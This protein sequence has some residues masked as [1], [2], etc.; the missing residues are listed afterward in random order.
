MRQT[1]ESKERRKASIC[2]PQVL[3][4]SVR[5]SC[6]LQCIWRHENAARNPQWTNNIGKY[7]KLLSH[8]ELLFWQE[9][10]QLAI[11]LSFQY[12]HS[13]IRYHLN[14]S[15]SYPDICLRST[16]QDVERK[17][18]LCRFSVALKLSAGQNQLVV[19]LWEEQQKWLFLH[20]VCHEAGPCTPFNRATG[21]A[22]LLT[23]FSWAVQFYC[24]KRGNGSLR[25]LSC[26]CWW[27]TKR[28][29]CSCSKHLGCESHP[30]I[31]S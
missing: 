18:H 16:Y 11:Q 1:L 9:S 12:S 31:N 7:T 19:A 14:N 15:A 17:R 29:T 2:L 10:Y 8:T 20:P 24:A 28:T 30:P 13:T 25:E 21:Q 3:Q 26:S 27:G 6:I 5:A 22:G 23:T 4:R